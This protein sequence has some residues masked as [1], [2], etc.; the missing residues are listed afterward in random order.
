MKTKDLLELLKI[1]VPRM[2]STIKRK[3]FDINDSVGSKILIVQSI[4]AT[5]NQLFLFHESKKQTGEDVGFELFKIT[6]SSVFVEYAY[7]MLK[8]NGYEANIEIIDSI[9]SNDYEK[10][11]YFLV[12]ESELFKQSLEMYNFFSEEMMQIASIS[13]DI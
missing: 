5:L 11:I 9:T 13:L 3:G 7:L 12:N 4:K 8:I 1:E 6:L 10:N 2:L